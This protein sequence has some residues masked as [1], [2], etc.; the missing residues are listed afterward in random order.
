VRYRDRF[1]RTVRNDDD[2]TLVKSA[3][4][5]MHRVLKD[6]ALCVSFCGWDHMDEFFAAWKGTGFR[7]VDQIIFAKDYTSSSRYVERRHE[8]AYVLA[9]GRPPVPEMPLPSVMPWAYSGNKAHPTEK[10]VR[11]LKPL[12]ESFCPPGGLVLD[13]FSGSGSTSVAA[14]LTGRRYCGI[15]LEDQ[16]VAHARRRLAGVARLLGPSGMN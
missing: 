15:E 12:I 16:Y 4:P 6:N 7:P 5:E 13:P 1:G 8:Q 10:H 11:T 14:A 9:K 3:F 2:L